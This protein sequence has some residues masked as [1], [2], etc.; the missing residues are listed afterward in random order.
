MK[1]LT[2]LSCA[3]F[4]LSTIAIADPG[5]DAERAIQQA[6][7]RQSGRDT[8]GEAPACTAEE[9]NQ[10]EDIVLEACLA[11]AAAFGTQRAL[12]CKMAQ[13]DGQSCQILCKQD[14]SPKLVAKLKL[15]FRSDCETATLRKTKIIWY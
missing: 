8:W 3:V 2:N 14:P 11:K 6:E 7:N 4:F 12:T 10:V 13:A 5:D 1:L 9:T 15:S